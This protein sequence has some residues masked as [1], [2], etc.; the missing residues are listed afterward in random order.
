MEGRAAALDVAGYHPDVLSGL[1]LAGANQQ[2]EPGQDDGILTALAVEELDLS[3]VQLAT[4]SACET[5][6]GQTAGG[7]GVLGLQRAFQLAGARSTVAMLWK[8][9]DKAS[10]LLMT[11]FYENLWDKDQHFSKLEALRQAQ[12]KMLREGAKRGVELPDDKTAHDGRMSPLYW[13]AFEL[14]GDWR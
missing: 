6:L 14:S 4:L 8:I 1:A 7:E 10:Q 9:P 11:D 12:L 2:A 13:A 5:G 3:H